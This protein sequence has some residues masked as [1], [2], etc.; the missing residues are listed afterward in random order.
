MAAARCPVSTHPNLT[1][2]MHSKRMFALNNLY[3][4]AHDRE[5]AA[6]QGNER[7]AVVILL[8][9]VLAATLSAI[10]KDVT[11][12]FDEVAHASYVADVQQSGDVWPDFA[13]MRMLDPSTFR[14]TGEMNY[15]NHPSPYYVL[16]A[17]V[18]PDLEGH[19]EAI[20]VYRVINILFVSI[21]LA[22]LLAIGVLARLPRL[23]FYAYSIPLV[24]IPVLAPLAGSINNDNAAFAGGGI[25]A[26]AMFQH[27]TRGRRGWLLA[28]LAGAV[29][30]SVAKLTA[31]LLVGG[32]VGGVLLWLFWRGRFQRGWTVP[33]I[34]AGLLAAA[35]Y[36][37][38]TVQY[39]SPAPS[40]QGVISML[41]AGALMRGWGAAERMSFVAFSID[42][43]GT[44]IAQWMPTLAPRNVLNEVVLII[45]VAAI[46]CALAGLVLS[47]RRMARRDEYPIDII[48][49]ASAL[50]FIATYVIHD[51]FSYERH[52]T[53]GWPPDAFP[54]YY[55]PLAFLV[56]L[57]GIV[58]LDSVKHSRGR[59][60]LA[61]F[62]VV[63]PLVFRLLGA[64][65]G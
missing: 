3:A 41:K 58:L 13:H 2:G 59:A 27:L 22:A 20:V 26:L 61:G 44:F 63:S 36:V 17:R 18:G 46:L 28:G 5:P 37:V 51:I 43:A 65:L 9:F 48:V 54:R 34:I 52:L 49:A 62:L 19:P 15:L 32:M 16:L 47:V 11:V 25:A 33:I 42:F 8:L 56:P 1:A 45:P 57:A 50:A 55:L 35:P 23:S 40:T 39:G 14:F 24:C 21:G 53:Y 12:G 10:H 31:L 38:L 7:V 60:V 64:P 30:A 6:S 29:A 4:L